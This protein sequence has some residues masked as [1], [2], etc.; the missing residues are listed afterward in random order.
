LSAPSPNSFQLQQQQQ[1]MLSNTMG[2][3]TIAVD[4]A[5]TTNTRRPKLRLDNLPMATPLLGPFTAPMPQFENQAFNPFFSNIRQNMELSHGPIRERFPI[6][7][8]SKCNV[9]PNN[10][11]HVQSV[12]TVPRCIASGHVGSNNLFQAPDWLQLTIKENGAQML[13][14]TYEVII[15]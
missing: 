7:L 5:S 15:V 11:Y 12:D 2:P 4:S 10:N 1:M 9:D 13:A 8:P 14:E 6:R 3:P